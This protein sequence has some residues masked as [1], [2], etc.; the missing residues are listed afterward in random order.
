MNLQRREKWQNPQRNVKERDV[1][2]LVEETSPRCEWPLGII[3]KANPDVDG[4]VRKVSVKVSNARAI[5]RGNKSKLVSEFQRPIQKIVLLIPVPD[6]L[7]P[8]A[9][10]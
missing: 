2:L 10:S 1:V 3:S 6:N 9:P 4:L 5:Q 8:N 7:N